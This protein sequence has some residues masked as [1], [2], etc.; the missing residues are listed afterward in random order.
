M[1]AVAIIQARMGSTR[2]PGK[3]LLDICG[4]PLL[5]RLIERVRSTTGIGR[6]VVATTTGADDDVLVDWCVSHEVPVY[7]G[8]VDDVLD[9][10]WRCAQQHTAEFIVRVTADDPLKDPQIIAEALALCASAPDVD[11]ASNTLNP[12]YPEGLDI[13]VVR[14]RALERAAREAKLP[15]EREHV[16]PYIWKNPQQFVLRSFCMQPDLSH[17]RW[18][19]DKPADLELMRCIFSHF[20]DKPLVSYQTVIA[21]LSENPELLSLNAGTV[22]HEGY[23]RALALEQKQ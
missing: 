17:W 10:F 21:W 14:Y 20:I 13:E 12:S 9:R 23:L 2:L 1:N 8:R 5:D 19:V 16:T 18:T 15:T 4:R 6:V 3:V 11:Y 22:R 7:R